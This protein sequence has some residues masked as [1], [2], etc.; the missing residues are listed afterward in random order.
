[1]LSKKDVKSIFCEIDE[2]RQEDTTI[3]EEPH[4][5]TQY[6]DGVLKKNW[7]YHRLYSCRECGWNLYSYTSENNRD[8][9]IGEGSVMILPANEVYISGI[10]LKATTVTEDGEKL[11]LTCIKPELWE[12]VS[13]IDFVGGGT[14]LIGGAADT[15]E[16][17]IATQANIGAGGVIDVG[18]E[19]NFEF[20]IGSN[21]EGKGKLIL[22]FLKFCAL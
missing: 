8:R 2:I 6:V 12:V 14:A 5:N 17:G 20:N 21:D 18:Y 22:K 9:K 1:M 3:G 7:K 10:A 19:K 11:I 15:D 4:D 16:Y 13:K